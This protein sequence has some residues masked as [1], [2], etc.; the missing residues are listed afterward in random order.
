MKI[1]RESTVQIRC[2][3]SKSRVAPTKE[4]SLD[5]RQTIPRLELLAATIRVRLTA[6][7]LEALHG[8]M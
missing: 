4:K 5:A 6:S 8:T 7:V 1:E 2:I 3:Q